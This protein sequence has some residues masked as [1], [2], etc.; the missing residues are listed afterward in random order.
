MASKADL[1]QEITS[2]SLRII[3]T[4][5][6]QD[7][8]QQAV[9]INRYRVNALVVENNRARA[10]DTFFYVLDEGTGNEAAYYRRKASDEAVK[11]AVR[12]YADSLIPGTFA[13][14]KVTEV[15]EDD[16]FALADAYELSGQQVT[17]KK[18]IIAR[19]NQNMVHREIV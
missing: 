1:I 9:N 10:R 14:I 7:A 17:L 4:V 5:P 12:T 16:G 2:R 8:A 18:I 19:V 6:E 11:A 3:E 15:N 13:R